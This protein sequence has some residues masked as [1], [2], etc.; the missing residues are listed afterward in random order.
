MW[1]NF[2][3]LKS[4]TKILIITIILS[5]TFRRC[6]NVSFVEFDYHMIHVKRV[7]NDFFRNVSG[8]SVYNKR[9]KQ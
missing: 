4:N 7:L 8:T 2:I 1:K 9:L 3:L 5:W 6:T